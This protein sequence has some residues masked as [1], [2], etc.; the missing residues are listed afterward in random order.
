MPGFV[1]EFPEAGED[2]TLTEGVRSPAE[3]AKG[4]CR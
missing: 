1:G 4:R 2:E 3:E